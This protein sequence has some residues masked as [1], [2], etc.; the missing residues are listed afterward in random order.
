MTLIRRTSPFGELL[1]FQRA[2]DRLFA[3]A[4]ARPG[5]LAPTVE[6]RLAMPVDVRVTPEAVLV[7]AALPGVKAEDVAVDVEGQTLTISAST[8]QG[9]TDGLAHQEIS[10]GRFARRLT[11]PNGLKPDAATAQFEDGLLRLS[12]PK[13]DEAKARRIPV[14]GGVEAAGRTATRAPAK[15]KAA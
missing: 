12:I 9:D 10:R 15:A 1:T 13:A 2:M 6:R 14:T 3:D 7:E 8:E 5:A 11:L 4:V